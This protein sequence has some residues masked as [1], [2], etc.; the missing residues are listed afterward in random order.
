MELTKKIV[1]ETAYHEGLVRQAYKDSEG[2]WTWC[3]GIT[4]ASGH[5]VSRYIDNPQPLQRCL[6]VWVWVLQKYADQVTDTLGENLTD[7]QKAAA[8]SFHY[9]TGGI[10]RAT[11]VSDF[12]NGDI[13]SSKKSFMNWRSPSSIIPRREAERDLFFDNKWSGD[14]TVTEYTRVKTNYTPDWSSA[15][16]ISIDSI[17]DTLLSK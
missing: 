6:E 15:R 17:L 3:V 7:A 9:N 14:G 4:D 10:Q 13:K 1:L 2:I 12:K 16:R 11:W 8:L 5:K